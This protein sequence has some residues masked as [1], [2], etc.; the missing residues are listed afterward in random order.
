MTFDTI[1]QKYLEDFKAVV[2]RAKSG[3]KKSVEMPSRPIVHEF[4]SKIVEICSSASVKPIT[5]HD[6]AL[7]RADRPDWRIEDPATFGIYCIGDHKN[8]S[9]SRSFRLT[10]GEKKQINRYMSYGRPVF[11]FDGIEFLFFDGDVDRPQRVPLIKKPLTFKDDW[12]SFR[13]NPSVELK[14]KKL[15][16]NPGSRPWNEEQLISLLAYRAKYLCDGILPYFGASKGSGSSIAEEKLI[17]TFSNIKVILEKHHDISLRNS[18]ACSEFVAQVVCFGLFYA[19]TRFATSKKTPEEKTD[20]IKEFWKLTKID[21]QT[22]KLRPFISLMELLSDRLLESNFVGDWYS[23]ITQILS[24]AQYV[25]IKGKPSNF[26]T[27]FETFLSKFSSETRY[28]RGAF[29]TPPELSAWMINA[30]EAISKKYLKRTIFDGPVQV[31]DPCCGTGTFVES[32]TS[33]IPKKLHEETIIYGFEILPAPYAL[34]HYRLQRSFRPEQQNKIQV[35]LTDTLADDLVGTKIIP[36]N[37]LDIEKAEAQKGIQNNFKFIFGNPPSSDPRKTSDRTIINKLMDDFRPDGSQ[38]RSRQNVQKA[39]QNEA[40][41]FLRWV[42][43]RAI[44]SKSCVV[45]LVL[46]SAFATSV[47]FKFAREFI[48]NLFNELFVLELDAD[49]R[50]G[51][52]TDSLFSVQ[53]GRLAIIAIKKNGKNGANRRFF[54]KSIADFNRPDKLAYLT[55]PF[56]YFDFSELQVEANFELSPIARFPAET[57]SKFSPI[58]S[59]NQ[60]LG[61]FKNKCSAIKLAPT[62]ALYHTQ[63][64]ILETRSRE[65]ASAK[66]LDAAIDKW[67]VGQQKPPKKE[68]FTFEVLDALSKINTSTEIIKY[69][70]RPFVEGWALNSADLFKALG[71]TPGSGTRARP[72]ILNAFTN[73]AIGIAISPAPSDVSDDIYRFASFSWNLPDNDLVARGNAMI[74]ASD[75]PDRNGNLVSNIS[76]S[77]ISLFKAFLSPSLSALSYIYAVISCYRYRIIFKGALFRGT[78]P[79]NPIRI[80]IFKDEVLRQNIADKG[81]ELAKCECFDNPIIPSGSIVI[82]LPEGFE[83]LELQRHIFD[84]GRSSI[85]LKG[86]KE[87]ITLSNI[88]NEVIET[89]ISGYD[90]VDKWLR[91][92]KFSYLK[93]TFQKKD[94]RELIELLTRIEKQINLIKIIDQFFEEGLRKNKF[95]DLI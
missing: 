17:N 9:L 44:E 8:L 31:I 51:M 93:R 27:L 54:Y 78:D 28:E 42:C 77:F 52:K 64:E 23:E 61:I 12:K 5:H 30:S 45:S 83:E 33:I 16:Q 10:L 53:Q 7:S 41:R 43:Q 58:L 84:I 15:L 57:W 63:K 26:H 72:E 22:K 47:S 82:D 1:S 70:Y 2:I 29:Y 76:D 94:L 34:A 75:H 6:T 68:K 81:L 66:F 50:R 21:E 73:G 59:N 40:Y 87:S 19:H 69:S 89:K 14:F 20:E 71:K 46:P 11:V 79:D 74:Y 25:G 88:N 32:L 13:I 90:V 56:D 38:K 86:H 85:I 60:T 39:L 48:L 37:E 36:I 24:H 91:E 80:P 65:I 49:A 3:G 4:I 67:F 62:S 18:V 35:L 55:K 92:R 95:L